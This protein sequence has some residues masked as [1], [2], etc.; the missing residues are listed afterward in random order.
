DPQAPTPPP[1]DNDTSIATTAFVKTQLAAYQPLD[2]D[3]TSLAAAATVGTFYYRQAANTWKPVI[4]GD[5]FVFDNLTGDLETTAPPG[6]GD[7]TAVDGPDPDDL[8]IF[9]GPT[10]IKGAK[11]G[12]GL[13]L[14]TVGTDR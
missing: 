6:M 7:V 4:L 11:I 13:S 10:S 5:G 8:A 1:S 3:L 2:G 9:V 14:D 12:T